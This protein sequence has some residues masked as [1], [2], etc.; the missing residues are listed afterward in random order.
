MQFEKTQFNR[1]IQTKRRFNEDGGRFN[2][3]LGDVGFSTTT[4]HFNLRKYKI[5]Q[6]AFVQDYISSALRR[7]EPNC[8]GCRVF[9]EKAFEHS[10]RDECDIVSRA[11][12]SV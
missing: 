3:S 8:C 11:I 7:R 1:R 6:R 10:G 2:Q 4:G 9:E 5:Q 12:N